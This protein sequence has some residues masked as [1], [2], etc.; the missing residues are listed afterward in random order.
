MQAL[1][2]SC[3]FLRLWWRWR[4]LGFTWREARKIARRCMA[5]YW[6]SDT[7]PLTFSDWLWIAGVMS[8]CGAFWGFCLYRGLL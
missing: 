1:T 3:R 7:E 2:R 8:A 6:P 4:Q 5:R